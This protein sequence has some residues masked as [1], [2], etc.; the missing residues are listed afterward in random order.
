MLSE[1]GVGVLVRTWHKLPAC[2][3]PEHRLEAYATAMHFR[4]YS[5]FRKGDDALRRRELY[6][7][8]A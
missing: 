6:L 3:Q 1:V 7:N 2:D 5:K 8:S 4:C